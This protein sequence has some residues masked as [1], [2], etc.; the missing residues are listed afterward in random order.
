[1]THTVWRE[2]GRWNRSMYAH[3]LLYRHNSF[4]KNCL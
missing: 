3:P 4:R 1:M 2:K